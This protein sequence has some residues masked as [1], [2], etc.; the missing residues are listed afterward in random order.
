MKAKIV[1]SKKIFTIITPATL[2]IM[3]LMAGFANGDEPNGL[4]VYQIQFTEAAD[5]TSPYAEMIVDCRGGIV[6]HKFAGYRPRFFIQ[7]PCYPDGWGAIQVKDWLTEQGYPIF[8]AV[9]PGDRVSLKNVQVEEYHGGGTVLQCYQEN[10]PVA[11]VRSSNNEIP[12]PLMV[13][14][15]EIAAPV[16]G[17]AGQWYLENYNAEKYEA[18]WLKVKNVT[19]GD[20]DLGKANDNYVL[21]DPL[22]PNDKC[23]AADYMNASKSPAH[24]YHYLV[25]TGEHFCSVSGIIEHYT[26]YNLEGQIYRFDYYQLITLN[27]ESFIGKIAADSDD[28]CDVDMTDFAKLVDNWLEINCQNSGGCNGADFTENGQ[29]DQQDLTKLGEYWLEGTM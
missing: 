23:W 13:T 12:G 14:P 29:V 10:D 5:G 3:A 6:V 21:Y 8:N 27:T 18:M 17:P 9:E 4:S 22:D 25:D 19:V 24:D 16:E 28:D 2:A 11:I 1:T 7:D 20:M 26:Q 15:D